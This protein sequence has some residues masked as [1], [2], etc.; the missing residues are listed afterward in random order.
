VGA[1]SRA[2][3]RWLPPA[4]WAAFV[5]FLGSRPA[6]QLPSGGIWGLP[7]IDKAAHAAVYGML[8]LLLA[9]ASGARRPARALL[10]GAL[11]GLFWGMLDEWVQGRVPGRTQAWTDLLA[12]V[13]GAG[14]GG[15]FRARIRPPRGG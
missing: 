14:A 2:A 15:Y 1:L 7:G 4:L 8:G 9:H 3:L 6:S 5:L 12:D 10:L 11:A 13:I